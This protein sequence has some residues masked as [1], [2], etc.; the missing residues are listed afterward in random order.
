VCL[1]LVPPRIVCVVDQFLTTRAGENFLSLLV[2]TSSMLD[3][4][5]I[6]TLNM[7]FDQLEISYDHT[8][9]ITQIQKTRSTFLPLVRMLDFN[10]SH[11]RNDA[12]HNLQKTLDAFG[13]PSQLVYLES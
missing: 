9:W 10:A 12:L 11:Y 6:K 13:V 2:A 1:S 7:V 8:P 4:G 3:S 5:A